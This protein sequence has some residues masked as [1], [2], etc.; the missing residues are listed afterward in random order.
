MP[1]KGWKSITI[2]E[3]VFQELLKYW[4][5]NINDYRKQ[6]ITSFSGFVTKMLYTN[7]ETTDGKEKNI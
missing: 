3:E 2:R 4:K 7:L 1:D 5:N 6:G